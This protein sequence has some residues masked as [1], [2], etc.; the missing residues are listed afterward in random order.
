MCVRALS[1]MRFPKPCD[2]IR[3]NPRV[4]LMHPLSVAAHPSLFQF[5]YV[6]DDK[7]TPAPFEPTVT[8]AQVQGGLLW[9]CKRRVVLWP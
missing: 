4:S 5:K 9:R 3:G 6:V 1:A 2:S 7:W 8:N